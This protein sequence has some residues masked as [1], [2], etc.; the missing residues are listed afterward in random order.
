[1]NPPPAA[2]VEV[3]V[4]K[5]TGFAAFTSQEIE[6]KVYATNPGTAGVTSHFQIKT[7]QDVTRDKVLLNKIL[8][9]INAFF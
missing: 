4:V 6:V 2:E 9:I 3:N 7:Y 1:M 5:I 8:L